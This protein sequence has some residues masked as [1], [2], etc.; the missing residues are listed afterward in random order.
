VNT[1]KIDQSFVRGVTD[2]PE[3]QAIVTAIVGLAESLCMKT[4]AEGVETIG[5]MEFLRSKGCD[6]MQGY[7]F[8]RP[9]PAQ[10]F[11]EF[12]RARSAP[13]DAASCGGR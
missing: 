4:I 13:G 11:A 2:N 8:A 6:Q 1:L 3:D 9:M 5:Q 7:L 10:H 12:A